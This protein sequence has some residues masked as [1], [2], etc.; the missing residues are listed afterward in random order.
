MENI[1]K[2]YYE[3]IS[4]P[5][6]LETVVTQA[7]R[8]GMWRHRALRW[9]SSA[10]A[11]LA[12]MLLCANV[13]PLY[14]AASEVPVLG[15]MVRIMRIGS[16]GESAETLGVTTKTVSQTVQLSFA[17]ADGTAASVPQYSVARRT[18]PFRVIL[19]LH[20][21]GSMDDNAFLDAVCKQAAVADAYRNACTVDTDR[22]FTI[23]LNKG[24]DCTA[25]EYT[26]GIFGMVFFQAED[27]AD[28]TSYYLRS[29][30]MA[31][32][33]KLAKQAEELAW[34]GATQVRMANGQYCVVLG[35]YTT[36][37]QA[38]HALSGLEEKLG[39]T[40]PF[41][42]AVGGVYTLPADKS[43]VS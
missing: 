29:D 11:M 28:K 34:E 40:L 17:A 2:Q 6:K 23:L 27:F 31:L 19:R 18:A 20:G 14:A 24:Y 36:E 26:T 8:R 30:A 32:G 13:T 12:A 41:S 3:A 25:G 37:E 33:P 5:E 43:A 1:G 38:R 9:G 21:I 22:S 16:G 10:A 4:L 42:V 7:I 39:R 35:N 15:Q